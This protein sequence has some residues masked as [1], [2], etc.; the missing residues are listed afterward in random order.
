M[1]KKWERNGKEMGKRKKMK[2]AYREPSVKIT[3]YIQDEAPGTYTF[4]YH[5]PRSI[6]DID[7]SILTYDILKYSKSDI[8][9]DDTINSIYEE[10]KATAW[11]GPP[12]PEFDLAP[13]AVQP[14]PHP[15]VLYIVMYNPLSYKSIRYE[16][17]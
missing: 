11:R 7:P 10:V 9:W 4:K 1:G 17:R 16:K 3:E 15:G 12:Y 5:R 14:E 8:V 2:I 6:K 13:Y